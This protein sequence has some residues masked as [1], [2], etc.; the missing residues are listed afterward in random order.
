VKWDPRHQEGIEGGGK[1]KKKK[2]SKGKT[3]DKLEHMVLSGKLTY[4]K[5]KSPTH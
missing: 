5:K 2:W 3:R 1:T 4:D